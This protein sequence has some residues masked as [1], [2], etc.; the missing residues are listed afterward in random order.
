[1]PNNP[2]EPFDY[3][4]LKL[5]AVFVPE[6]GKDQVSATD[7]INPLGLASANDI[8]PNPES[9]QNSQQQEQ[10]AAQSP[11][12]PGAAPG[13][14]IPGTNA[15]PLGPLSADVENALPAGESELGHIF[16]DVA[17]HLPDTSANRQLLQ[18]VANDPKG[19]MGTDQFGNTWSAKTLPDGTQVWTQT[20]NGQIING[21]LNQTPRAFNPQTG[22]SAPVRPGG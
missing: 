8:E 15:L 14:T 13:S 6:D 21:G 12:G 16:R 19:S 17:G 9:P 10:Q 1:M 4:T 22:L 3:D 20:R 11:V 7:I 18:G 5:R 2:D